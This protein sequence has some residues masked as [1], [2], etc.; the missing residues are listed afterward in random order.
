[1][2]FRV[3]CVRWGRRDARGPSAAIRRRVMFW[4]DQRSSHTIEMRWLGRRH[5]LPDDDASHA[6]DKIQTAVAVHL[7]PAVGRFPRGR[8]P[9]HGL[10][11]LAAPPWAQRWTG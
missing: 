11:R 9:E 4:R 3:Q 8:T 6:L 1:M 7:N 10:V 2:H 5:E